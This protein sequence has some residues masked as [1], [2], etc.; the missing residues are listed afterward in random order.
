M[1]SIGAAGELPDAAAH[2]NAGLGFALCL[3]IHDDRHIPQ[4]IV[5]AEFAQQKYQIFLVAVVLTGKLPRVNDERGGTPHSHHILQFCTLADEV[6]GWGRHAMKV[7]IFEMLKFSAENILHPAIDL[8]HRK[9]RIDIH[10]AFALFGKM[11]RLMQSN[12]AVCGGI[13]AKIHRDLKWHSIDV[14]FG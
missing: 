2:L 5:L 4:I 12:V 7:R 13:L 9:A 11:A 1:D 6:A 3:R 10:H 8:A 14:G